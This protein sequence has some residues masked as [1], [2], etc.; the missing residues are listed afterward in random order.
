MKKS[1]FDAD[2]GAKTP[3]ASA[4][5]RARRWLSDLFARIHGAVHT[6]AQSNQNAQSPE[7]IPLVDLGPSADSNEKEEPVDEKGDYNVREG[8]SYLPYKNVTCLQHEPMRWYFRRLPARLKGLRLRNSN[9][10]IK[11]ENIT[12]LH[13]AFEDAL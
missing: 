2:S 11:I 1:T 9:E 10:S 7:E 8:T 3:E 5:I 4:A 6:I 12:S 13:N